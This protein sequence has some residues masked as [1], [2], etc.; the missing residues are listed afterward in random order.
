MSLRVI[1]DETKKQQCSLLRTAR[2]TSWLGTPRRVFWIGAL[3]PAPVL[4]TYC[5]TPR[6]H[7]CDSWSPSEVVAGCPLYRMCLQINGSGRRTVRSFPPV[8]PDH[9]YPPSGGALR[10]NPRRRGALRY[11]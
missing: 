9:A 6:G 11:S 3:A 10:Q 1:G 5:Q 2:R 7:L 4:E 8:L